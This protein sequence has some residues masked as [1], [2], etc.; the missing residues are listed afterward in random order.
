MEFTIALSVSLVSF[1]C[2][3]VFSLTPNK[4][5]RITTENCAAD[6][7]ENCATDEKSANALDIKTQNSRK[8]KR[9]T[10]ENLPGNANVA[11]PAAAAPVVPL[12]VNYHFTRKCNY[13]CGFCF[14]T[15]KTSFVLPIEDAKKGLALLKDAGMF[16]PSVLGAG[17][18]GGV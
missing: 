6:E 8:F 17:E 13:Q 18:G 15:A 4:K 3:I 2:L 16:I 14:H 5:K 7:T 9:W 10:G 11:V 1:I 12:S